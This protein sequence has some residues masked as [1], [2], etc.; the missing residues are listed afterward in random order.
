MIT[1]GTVVEDQAGVVFVVAAVRAAGLYLVGVDAAGQRSRVERRVPD[2]RGYRVRGDLRAVV[3]G[4]GYVL[5]VEAA[6]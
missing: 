2:G 5:G 1:K 3:S 6:G 4:Q